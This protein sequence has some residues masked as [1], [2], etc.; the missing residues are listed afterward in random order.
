MEQIK[1]ANRMYTNDS[2]HLRK[3]LSI[4][5][6]PDSNSGVESPPDRRAD[7]PAAGEQDGGGPPAE[8]LSPEEF[9]KRLDGL[10]QQSK[11]AAARGCRVGGERLLVGVPPWLTSCPR[12]S[13]SVL[14]PRRFAAVDEVCGGAAPAPRPPLG[15]QSALPAHAAVPLTV[16]RLTKNLRDREDEIFQL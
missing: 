3:S 10:I 6:M 1:R 5:V 8:E 2:I 9:L 13:V 4:P 16:T 11:Q 15:P 12:D 7:A 14:P